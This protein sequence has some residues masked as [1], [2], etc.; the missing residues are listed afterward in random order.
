M[1]VRES[2]NDWMDR[3][4]RSHYAEGF[5]F[6]TPRFRPSI[7]ISRQCG[8]G[9][10]RIGESLADY[11]DEV[12]DS[13][14]LGWALFDQSLVGRIIE[15]NKLPDSEEPFIAKR[16]KFAFSDTLEE[17]LNLEPSQWSLFHYSANTIRKLCKLGNAIIIGRGGNFITSDLPNTFHARLV[18]S[19]GL[20]IARIRKRMGLSLEEATSQ[21][22]EIDK[23]R[24]KYVKCYTGA[25]INSPTHY[26]LLLNIDDLPD[27]IVVRILGDSLLEWATEK[28][29][30]L[31]LTTA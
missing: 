7:T 12:D 25:N 16:A 31:A 19:K 6:R 22:T 3:F 17:M 8:I 30:E 21:V 13:T 14:E 29:K 2:S 24:R 18:G 20:R 11:L 15:Q 27:D 9:I 4:L 26:H 23:S 1:K 10:S 5:A 28:E